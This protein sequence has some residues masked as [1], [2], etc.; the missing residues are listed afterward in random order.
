MKYNENLK[1]SKKSLEHTADTLVDCV[2]C[3]HC[4]TINIAKHNIKILLPVISTEF[5]IDLHF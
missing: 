2:Q 3:V 5:N 4:T 1:K